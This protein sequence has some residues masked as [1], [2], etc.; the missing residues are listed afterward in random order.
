MYKLIIFQ[1]RVS[2]HNVETRC[3]VFEFKT[4]LAVLEAFSF[5]NK[6]GG[7]AATWVLDENNPSF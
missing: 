4:K 1:D 6:V 7:V 2:T 3:Y 5:F